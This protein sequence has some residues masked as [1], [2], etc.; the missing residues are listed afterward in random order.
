MSQYDEGL[1]EKFFEEYIEDYETF[2]LSY[3][4]DKAKGRLIRMTNGDK[5]LADRVIAAYHKRTKRFI[6]AIDPRVMRS[7]PNFET[8]YPG[9]DFPQAWCW[10]NYKKL[11]IEKG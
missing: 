10:P 9:P 3:P 1:F 6:D 2:I 11:L 5:E 8:D 4:P 7:V